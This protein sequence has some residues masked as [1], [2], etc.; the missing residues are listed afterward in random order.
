MLAGFLFAATLEGTIKKVDADKSI[1]VVTGKDKK[2]VTFTFTKD[3]K[4][5][6]DGKGAALTDLK[7][8]QKAKVTHEDN[9]ATPARRHRPKGNEVLPVGRGELAH[10]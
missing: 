1:L 10:A 9:Q 2:D 6:L 4:I 8:D 7:K 3:A 5:T